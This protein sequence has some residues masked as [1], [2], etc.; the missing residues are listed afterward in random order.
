[1][2]EVS[3]VEA[4]VEQVENEV[5]NAG[6]AGRVVALWVRIGRLSGVNADS[7][8]FAFEMVTPETSLANVRLEI[9]LSPA[10]CR[11]SACGART[12]IDDLVPFCP[13]CGSP[14]IHFEGGRELMLDSIEL[15]ENL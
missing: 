13:A 9:D 14:A 6:H 8:R 1:M 11:C 3:L 5:R 4:L 10:A 15:E 7:F 2:H 12:P